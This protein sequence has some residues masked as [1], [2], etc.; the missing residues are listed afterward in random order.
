MN[1]VDEFVQGLF[2]C[3]MTF[4]QAI[5]IAEE[6]SAGVIKLELTDSNDDPLYG[7]VV[8]RGGEETKEILGAVEA[9]EQSW[10]DELPSGGALA[11]TPCQ[12]LS[13]ELKSIAALNTVSVLIE[14]SESLH[15][16]LLAHLK[17]RPHLD[18]NEAIV[19]AI[20]L[21]LSEGENNG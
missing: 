19:Q 10:Q 11:A 9:I 1:G 2:S 14:I 15:A 4:R 21:M 16:R 3:D 8:V 6:Y 13:S 12:P 7:L 17:A 20:S 18:M 5:A